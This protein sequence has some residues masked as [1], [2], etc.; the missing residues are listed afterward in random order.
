M[1]AHGHGGRHAVDPIQLGDDIEQEFRRGV[2]PLIQEVEPSEI[3]LDKRGMQ[4]SGVAGA[5]IAAWLADYRYR[6][7][8]G[9]YVP[10]SVIETNL[11]NQ[12]SFAAA[13]PTSFLDTL[14]TTDP[15]VYGATSYTEADLPDGPKPR[16]QNGSAPGSTA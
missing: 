4:D 10:R 8:I 16:T 9:P 3:F 2:L 5:D 6:D 13:F 12:K 15:A 1:P 14:A 11:L 7:N